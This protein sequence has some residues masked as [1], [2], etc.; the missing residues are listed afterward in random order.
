MQRE[1]M[2]H[3]CQCAAWN[4]Q[5]DV[6]Q[7]YVRSMNKN[8]NKIESIGAVATKLE[9]AATLLQADTTLFQADTTLLQAD[10]VE[11]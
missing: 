8:G 3:E 1:T 7:G 6:H 11:M 5:G 4:S 10:T 9:Q 2:M